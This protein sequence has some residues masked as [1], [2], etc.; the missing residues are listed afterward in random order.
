MGHWVSFKWAGLQMSAHVNYTPGDPGRLSGPPEKCYPPEAAEIDFISLECGQSD[1]RFLL[2][3]THSEDIE[4]A[5]LD[6][7]EEELRDDRP[8]YEPDPPEEE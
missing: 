8:D 3:S 5:A 7:L 6:A 2:D 1:A 4:N